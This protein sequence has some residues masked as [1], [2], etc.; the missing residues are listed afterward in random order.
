M[1]T[2]KVTMTETYVGAMR[3]DDDADPWVE[4]YDILYFS[5]R[6]CISTQIVDIEE[7]KE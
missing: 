4:V 7:V 2:Y 3:L 5:N 6:K 1:K